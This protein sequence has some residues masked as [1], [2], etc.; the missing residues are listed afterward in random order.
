MK[1]IPAVLVLLPALLVASIS[2]CEAQTSFEREILTALEVCVEATNSGDPDA[3][4]D[5]DVDSPATGTIGDGLVYTGWSSVS[6]LLWS[7]Y[8]QSGAVQLQAADVT[9]TPVGSDGAVAYFT[10]DWA[11]GSPVQTRS[12]GAMTIVFVRTGQGWKVAH[13]HTSTLPGATTTSSS[14]PPPIGDGP[15][16][17]VRLTEPCDVT[18][19]VDGDT[20]DCEPFGRIRL[21]GMDTPEADQEPFGKM[22]TQILANLIPVGSEVFIEPDVEATDQYGR[23]L[24]YIW[25]GVGMVNWTMV[26]AGHAVV[27]TYPPNVQYVDWFESAQIM[28]RSEN[29]GLWEIDGFECEPRAHRRGQC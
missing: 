25:S 27:L 19:I 29:A 21:I 23:I 22:A 13:D 9:V 2:A 20:I 18:R 3:V 24:S 15:V 16:E 7:I 26:R 8:A 12:R 6:D 17:P 11:F 10:A 14:A 28:A 1:N 5:L 4:A